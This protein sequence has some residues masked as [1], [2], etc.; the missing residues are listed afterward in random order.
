MYESCQALGRQ[1]GQLQSQL[2]VLED[3]VG[4]HLL[5]PLADVDVAL[6]HLGE[7]GD[8]AAVL[9]LTTVLDVLHVKHPPVLVAAVPKSKVDAGAAL[10]GG[11]HEVSHD[12]GD[13]E[14]QLAL[15]PLGHL[16]VPVVALLDLGLAAGVNL[17]RAIFSWPLW[18]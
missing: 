8:V 11:P 12:P 17:L 6:E 15:G 14:G 3:G 7:L 10:G 16:H 5:V 18:G 4:Q 9:D 13:V 2:G 1:V